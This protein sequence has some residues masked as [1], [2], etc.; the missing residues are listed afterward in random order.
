MRILFLLLLLVSCSTMNRTKT[1]YILVL[2][3]GDNVFKTVEEFVKKQEI[4]GATMF[5][6]GFVKVKF[7]YFKAEEKK[8]DEREMPPMELASFTGTIAWEGKEP[9]IHAHGVVSG[10]DFMAY[11]GHILDATVGKGTMEI[12]ILDHGQKLKRK[13]D[14]QL[15]AKVLIP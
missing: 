8:Y 7:G 6:T 10:E 1:G 4:Q 5:G 2:K 15:G 13:E 14:K 9:S 3:E 12:T 11:G